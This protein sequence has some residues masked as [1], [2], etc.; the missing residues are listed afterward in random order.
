MFGK[1]QCAA[2]QQNYSLAL[3]L[4]N[5]AVVM[6]SNFL[7]AILE[8]MKLQLAMH[9][10]EQVVD[11]AQRSKFTAKQYDC[12]ISMSKKQEM[13]LLRFLITQEESFLVKHW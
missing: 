2:L 3:D 11:S 8:K 4:M 5:R 12:S 7:P 9:D 13:D 10:W 6:V 1:A